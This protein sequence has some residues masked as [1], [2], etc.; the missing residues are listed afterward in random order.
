MVVARPLVVMV[1]RILGPGPLRL[2][3]VRLAHGMPASAYA[4][5]GHNGY[6]GDDAE[7]TEPTQ[8]AA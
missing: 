8:R 2:K 4:V 5:A 7:A 1:A 3:L 6:A